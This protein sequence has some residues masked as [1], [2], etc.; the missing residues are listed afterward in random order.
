MPLNGDTQFPG[1]VAACLHFRRQ[2]YEDPRVNRRKADPRASLSHASE[3]RSDAG[4]RCYEVGLLAATT[5]P[6]LPALVHGIHERTLTGSP[7]AG[8]G[9][10]RGE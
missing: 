9:R 2:R 4:P 6:L 5:L 10:G 3:N 1:A 8:A 7:C